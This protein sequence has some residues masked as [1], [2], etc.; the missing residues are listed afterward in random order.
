MAV[1]GARLLTVSEGSGGQPWAGKG[2]APPNPE[3]R[4]VESMKEESGEDCSGQSRKTPSKACEG[5]AC[6]WDGVL[7]EGSLALL[8]HGQTTTSSPWTVES[9]EG[10][11]PWREF[12]RN[13]KQ[14]PPKG[15]EW[16]GT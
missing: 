4:A 12:G 3:A 11:P 13:Y 10:S 2:M 15:L 14:N 6:H 1:A 9:W 5:Q 7:Q 8:L 16:G